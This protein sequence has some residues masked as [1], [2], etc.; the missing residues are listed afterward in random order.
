MT[1]S[2]MLGQ[3]KRVGVGTA[4]KS[5]LVVMCYEKAIEMVRSAKR[6]YEEKEYEKKAKALQK[7]LEVINTL[8]SCLDMEKGGQIARNLE[9]I[10]IY[11]TR[12]LL[13]GDIRKDLTV[14]D[15]AVRILSELKEA[16][17]AIAFPSNTKQEPVRETPNAG[18]SR[19]AA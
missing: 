2:R 18:M 12:R 8:Q 15:E 10:Y 7:S 16:W 3:Y 17:E 5:E 4:G 6:F 19:I 1:Y 11:L 13:E 9:A 14:F